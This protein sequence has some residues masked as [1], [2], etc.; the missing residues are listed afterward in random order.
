LLRATQEKGFKAT[1][2]EFLEEYIKIHK[3]RE[4]GSAD[5]SPTYIKDL[6]AGRPVFSHPSRSGGF[7][8]RYGRT[9]TSGFS[10]EAIHPATMGITDGFLAFGTQLKIEKP[11]KGCALGI[12]DEIDGPV[13]KL[14]NGGVKRV[15]TYE[16]AKKIYPDVEEII[17]LGDILFAFGDVANRDGI[18]EGCCG[19]GRES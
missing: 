15:Y 10:A 4:K 13:V 5:A 2:W 16:E 18:K 1:G 19:C 7:R 14:R 12:C 11:T 17:Y 9:R 6:V 8:F 3:K